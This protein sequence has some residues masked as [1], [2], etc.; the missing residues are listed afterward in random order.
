MLVII[1]GGAWLGVYLDGRNQMNFP[2]YTV[3]I[4]LLAV[5]IALY[6]TLRDFIGK[7]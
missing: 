2:I 5:F 3:V 1:G 6:L 4:T 7:N